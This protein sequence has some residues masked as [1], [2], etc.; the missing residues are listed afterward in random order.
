MAEGAARTLPT[1]P[2][3]VCMIFEIPSNP[4][5]LYGSVINDSVASKPV[6]KHLR[7]SDR[8]ELCL[9]FPPFPSH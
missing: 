9:S 1:Q 8:L 2:F 7:A 4:S 6:S 5:I 3:Y